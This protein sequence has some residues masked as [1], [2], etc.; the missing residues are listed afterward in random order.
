MK[1]FKQT[2]IAGLLFLIPLALLLIVFL[3]LFEILRIMANPLKDLLPIDRF[4]GIAVADLIVI[5][6]L[7]ILC[8]TA[9]WM[10]RREWAKKLQASIE[11]K[12]LKKIPG[13]AIIQGVTNDL[14]ATE[15]ASS[16]FTPVLVRFDDQEQLCFQ[17][18]V[19]NDSRV[20]VFVPGAPSPWSG[21]VVYVDKTRVSKLDLS[22]AAAAENIKNLGLNSEALF[23]KTH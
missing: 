9:G 13:Y 12:I 6:F 11:D 14:R 2:L 23:S 3:K 7:F 20:V 18:E 17:I 19:L 10:A 1:T 5:V 15:E 4:L 16:K 21:A 22:V 8:L